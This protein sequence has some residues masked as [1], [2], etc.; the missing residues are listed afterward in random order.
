[1]L[2][3]GDILVTYAENTFQYLGTYYNF[4]EC[5]LN[6]FPLK[7]GFKR[8]YKIAMDYTDNKTAGSTFIQLITADSTSEVQVD[9]PFT[10][11]S[12][13][14]HIGHMN[15]GKKPETE[16][17]IVDI[18][19][20]QGNIIIRVTPDGT[21]GGQTRIRKVSILVYDILE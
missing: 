4:L 2:W 20:L 18:T 17:E 19:K 14:S 7:A 21:N 13:D 11:G 15:I 10:W 12:A 16:E 1:M 8:V 6:L 3:Q 9:F 5:I